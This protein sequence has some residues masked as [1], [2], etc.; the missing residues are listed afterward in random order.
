MK[1]RLTLWGL[2]VWAM[3]LMACNS[4]ELKPFRASVHVGA[5]ERTTQA[6]VRKV[7]I[8][9]MVDDSSSMC[10]EQMELAANFNAF[11]EN[12]ILVN[13]DFHL[14][15]VNSDMINSPGAFQTQ[16]GTFDGLT[17]VGACSAEDKAELESQTAECSGR[18][19]P[20]DGILRREEYGVDLSDPVVLAELQADF[21]CLA[22]TGINGSAVEMGLESVREALE[23]GRK[24]GFLRT[25]EK[26]LLSIVFVTDENDCSDGT[27]RASRGELYDLAVNDGDQCEYARN[28]EDSCALATNDAP[29]THTYTDANGE[30]VTETRAGV[31]W[32]VD[33][34]RAI[35]EAL[36]DSGQLQVDCGPSGVCANGLVSRRAFF[37]YLTL[38]I[39]ACSQDSEMSCRGDFDCRETCLF[40]DNTGLGY[41][42]DDLIVAAI[43]NPDTGE[44]LDPD[45]TGIG[46]ILPSICGSQGQSGYRYDLF[47]RMFNERQLV[48]AEICQTSGEDEGLPALFAEPLQVIGQ[49][50]GG[51]LS[52]VC[53]AGEPM[54]CETDADC[55]NDQVCG[56]DPGCSPEQDAA[57]LCDMNRTYLEGTEAEY[58]VCS[59]FQVVVGT[60][61]AAGVVTDL[62]QGVDFKVNYD[63]YNQCG[64][65]P[66]SVRFLRSPAD[67]IVV[68]YARTLSRSVNN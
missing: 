1:R 47:A 46:G 55:P 24:N 35:V 51:L 15:V 23:A 8:L 20:A 22:L 38:P 17:S 2:V 36:V 32:C 42:V 59:G 67:E 63:A 29:I 12:L 52:E 13:A 25:S 14:A 48:I 11:I 45:D 4:H 50:I 60:E 53:L 31:E 30:E 57:S 40:N 49:T 18:D 62:V 28:I 7:D 10:Q 68:R 65:S 37:D 39:G 58:R 21:R 61:S 16:P 5:V 26:A 64:S 66:I 6:E 54:T 41:P 3:T 33:G 9:F 43:V 34:D 19:L 27:N 56:F 44:R